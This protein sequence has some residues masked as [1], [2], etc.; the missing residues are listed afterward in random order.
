[1]YGLPAVAA[2]GGGAS[3]PIEHGVNGFV[4]RNEAAMLADAVGEALMDESRYAMLSDG[5]A[6]AARSFGV[7]AMGDSVLS[8]YRRVIAEH[9]RQPEFNDW[10]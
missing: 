3:A 7:E 5:A 10:I 1:M 2:L 8:V 6:R 9:A 4:V